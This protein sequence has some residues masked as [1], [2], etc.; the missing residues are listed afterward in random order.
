MKCAFCDANAWYRC[1]ISGRIV[2][3]EHAR[4]LIVAMKDS[5][6]AAG[7]IVIKASSDED[8][9]RIQELAD[10]FWGETEID[11]F[12]RTYDVT[13]LPALVACVEDNVVGFLSYAIE[14]EGM[15]IVLLS[16]LP[17]YQGQGIAER[18]IEGVVQK[19]EELDL[20]RIAVATS[21]DDLLALYLY[22]RSG[23]MITGIQVGGILRHHGREEKGFAEIPIRDE[24]QLERWLF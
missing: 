12:G 13:R 17:N 19:A 2:C 24:I 20:S 18:L 5:K 15:V 6:S 23:F 9:G 10:Y 3:A 16:V 7:S 4:M 1:P 8:I 21:N 14:D 22:Q 11:C